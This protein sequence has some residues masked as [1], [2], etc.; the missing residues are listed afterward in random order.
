[1]QSFVENHIPPLSP[2]CAHLLII[3]KCNH[4]PFCFQNRRDFTAF[5]SKLGGKGLTL[6][7]A[8]CERLKCVI[9]RQMKGCVF[10]CCHV[11]CGALN[12]LVGCLLPTNMQHEEP[13]CEASC[14]GICM[15]HVTY[16]HTHTCTDSDDSSEAMSSF[17]DNVLECQNVQ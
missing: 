2:A 3:F 15:F 13:V 12:T 5:R 4:L 16:T 11:G 14:F 6:N 17:N 9:T 7:I 8:A 10:P 1:M